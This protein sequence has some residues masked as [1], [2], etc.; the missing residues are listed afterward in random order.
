M[1]WCIVP[2]DGGKRTPAQRAAMLQRLGFGWLAYDYRAEHVPTF[3][4]ELVQLKKHGVRLLAWWFPGELNE[5]ARQILDVLKRH[6]QRGVQLWVTG[7]GEPVRDAAEE[8]ARI[9]G[10]VR[11][12]R[13]IAEAAARQ[14]C[15]VALYNHG[16]WFGEPENQI[17]IIQRLKADGVTNVGIVYNQHHGHAHL[18]RFEDLLRRM[19]PHLLAFNLNGMTRD[20]DQHGKKILPLGQGDL[21]LMLLRLLQDSGWQG[22]VGLL[23]HTDEDAE[24][25]LRDN[26]AG[27]DWLVAQL[28]GRPA[29]PRP[30]PTSWR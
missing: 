22:P 28:A 4:D 6:D 2:F 26:L 21:D 15:V 18:D 12:L 30:Q 8:K 5:E 17:Q 11:R 13:P 10:E 25:R 23:N 3:D 20:G 29:A 9:E 27:L 7:G 1:A 24:A 16:G 19:K 14:D